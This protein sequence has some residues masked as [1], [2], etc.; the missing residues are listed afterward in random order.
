MNDALFS[1]SEVKVGDS[2]VV[3]VL[4]QGI[5]HFRCEGI[6]RGVLIDG[7]DDVIDSRKGP[8][9]VFD[10]QSE[11]PDHA[12][13]LRTGHLVDKVRSDEKLCAAIA[14]SAHGMSIPDFLV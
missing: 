1:R 6:S 14:Q 8:M 11:I 2:K 12:E 4:P 13:S 5:H 10:L 7:R 3:G 9:G